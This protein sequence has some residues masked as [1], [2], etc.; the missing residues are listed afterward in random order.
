M[1]MHAYTT[2]CTITRDPHITWVLLRP[3]GS[4]KN[5]ARYWANRY[6]AVTDHLHAERKLHVVQANNYVNSSISYSQ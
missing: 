6:V 5:Y 3:G 1:Y 2:Q 4:S